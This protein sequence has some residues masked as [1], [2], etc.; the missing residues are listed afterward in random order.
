MMLKE[1]T[2]LLQKFILHFSSSSF[3]VKTFLSAKQMELDKIPLEI[4]KIFEL[5][6]IFSTI[7]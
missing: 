1:V 5:K 4:N 2:K 7:I 6:N 3:S